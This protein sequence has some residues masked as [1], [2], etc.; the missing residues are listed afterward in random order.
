MAIWTYVLVRDFGFAPNPFYKVC[1]LATCKPVI[2]NGAKI[3]DWVLG[4][5]SNKKGSAVSGK[6]IYA[7]R[8]QKK[9]TF[10]EYWSAEEY[11][12]K[13]PI[14]NG[15]LMQK[16]GDNIYHHVREA[17]MQENSH[18]ANK[19]GSINYINLNR[20]TSCDAVLLS[21]EYWYWGRDAVSL[22]D[23]LKML[24]GS[25]RGCKKHPDDNLE[26][27]LSDWLHA[28]PDNGLIRYPAKFGGEFER[29]NGK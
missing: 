29:Y 10:D 9:L 28:M 26:K 25:G 12:T 27:N 23:S 11:Y 1:S 18:H 7:M 13:H 8:V 14:M 17:W 21:Q 6:L 22:P 19:D 15:S 24:I 3:N 16:Y 4:F 5:G 20:D 2:R